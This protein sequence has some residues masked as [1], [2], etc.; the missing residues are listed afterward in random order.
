MNI[1]VLAVLVLMVVPSLASAQNASLPGAW[2]RVSI[3]GADGNLAQP[4]PPAAF[5]VMTAD[6]FW[7]QTASPIGRAKINK[8]VKDLSREELISRFTEVE[9]R[10]GTYTAVAGKLTR[11]NVSSGNPNDEG[12]DQVQMFTIDGDTLILTSPDP[13][14]KA[15]VRFRRVKKST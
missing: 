1:R 6:G 5:L 9:G 3:K 15:E 2:E 11:H 10:R 4:Q 7:S 13:K 14:S 8:P 12:T